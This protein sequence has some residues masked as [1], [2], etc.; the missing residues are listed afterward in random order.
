MLHSLQFFWRFSRDMNSWYRSFFQEQLLSK[1]S[2][3]LTLICKAVWCVKW[4]AQ[5]RKHWCWSWGIFPS[6]TKLSHCVFSGSDLGTSKWLLCSLLHPRTEHHNRLDAILLIDSAPA[7]QQWPRRSARTM[8]DSSLTSEGG[9]VL[10]RCCQSTVVG[11]ASD[12]TSR[13]ETGKHIRR[14]KKDHWMVFY[15]MMVV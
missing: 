10:K 4:F 9:S 11:G 12:L 6:K 15:H 3:I 7:Y 14:L 1:T 13:F 2:F 5:T 8:I